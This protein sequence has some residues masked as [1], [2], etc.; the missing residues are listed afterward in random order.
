M[1]VRRSALCGIA[2][3]ATVACATA[4]SKHVEDEIPADDLALEVENHNWSDVVI[5]VVHD[6][7]YTRFLQLSA[8][9]SAAQTIPARLV[10]SNGTLRLLVHR[11]GGV[12]DY[13]TPTVSVRTG[14]TV[15]LT[16]E[17]NL[18][19]SSLGVW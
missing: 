8:A 7:T 13:L 15:A 1:D 14:K 11:I 19:R 3:V 10:G 16:L 17:S 12:D 4:Q 18:E 5:Y 2:T 9:K 6:G